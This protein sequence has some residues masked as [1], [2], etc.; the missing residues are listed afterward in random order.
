MVVPE[1]D[2]AETAGGAV[3]NEA[4]ATHRVGTVFLTGSFALGRPC[5]MPL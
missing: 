5:S 2:M 3:T 1:M 4:R